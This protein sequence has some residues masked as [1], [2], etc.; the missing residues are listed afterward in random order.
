MKYFIL[1]SSLIQRWGE[2][3]KF[4]FWYISLMLQ[5]KWNI[6]HEKKVPQESNSGPLRRTVQLTA[7]TSPSSHSLIIAQVA[8]S[9]A[10]YSFWTNGKNWHKSLKQQAL[11]ENKS[12]YF[13]NKSR[14]FPTNKIVRMKS[15]ANEIKKMNFNEAHLNEEL[16]RNFFLVIF[17]RAIKLLNEVLGVY[18]VADFRLGIF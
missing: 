12:K 5:V 1:H 15:T 13:L 9:K 14:A 6:F 16:D 3:Y 18:E 11:S 8:E 4:V 2:R 7:F 10:I 17:D